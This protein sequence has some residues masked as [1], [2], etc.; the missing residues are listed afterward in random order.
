MINWRRKEIKM[1]NEYQ[2]KYAEQNHNL[3][4]GIL[5]DKNLSIDEFYDVAAI[6]LCKAAETY[7][8]TRENFATYAYT[9]MGNEINL[10]FQKSNAKSRIQKQ[11]LLYYM[12]QD[13]NAE[14]TKYLD[15]LPAKSNVENEAIFN[16]EF[17]RFCNSLS[18]KEIEKLQII[19]KY[20]VADGARKLSITKQALWKF[21][22]NMKY[23]Y[24]CFS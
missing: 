24:T 14:D 2:Q 6:G 12:Q 22:N 19:A 9:C 1:L 15:L 23:R 7:D 20:G 11:N 8:E 13:E 18:Q 5:N 4:Y 3:I 17:E 21:Q 10:Y 16:V